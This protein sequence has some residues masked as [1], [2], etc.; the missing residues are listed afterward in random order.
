[1]RFIRSLQI[2][3]MNTLNVPLRF[4]LDKIRSADRRVRLHIK[5]AEPDEVCS[6]LFI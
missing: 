5:K 4:A 1:M 2:D 3:G 6:C